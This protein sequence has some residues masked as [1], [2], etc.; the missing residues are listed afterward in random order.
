[1]TAPLPNSEGAILPLF[2]ES[3]K[4]YNNLCFTLEATIAKLAPLNFELN[5]ERL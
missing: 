1:M 4:N 5:N 2:P 3:D